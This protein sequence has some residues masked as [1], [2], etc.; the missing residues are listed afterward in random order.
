METLS[1]TVDAMAERCGVS[2]KAVYKWR[3]GHNLPSNRVIQL[4]EELECSTDYILL[5]VGNPDVTG[6]AHL[7]GQM[8]VYDREL[9]LAFLRASYQK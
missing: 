4:S 6:A 8:P 1:T 9:L 2:I 5:G 3:A 7:L